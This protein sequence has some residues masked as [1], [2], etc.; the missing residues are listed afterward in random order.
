MTDIVQLQKFLQ[1]LEG[2]GFS[3]GVRGFIS[4]AASGN[5]LTAPANTKRI[6]D[7]AQ[8]SVRQFQAGL[9]NIDEA[10]SLIKRQDFMVGTA[11]G[12]AALGL[13]ALEV[14]YSTSKTEGAYETERDAYLNNA[15]RVALATIAGYKAANA[16]SIGGKMVWYGGA[17]AMVGVGGGSI[18][19]E[20]TGSDITDAKALIQAE[21][22]NLE[23]QASTKRES[24]SA[25]RDEI[26]QSISDLTEQRDNM[27]AP[28]NSDGLR[29]ERDQIASDI[30][31]T[32]RQIDA[33]EVRAG[34]DVARRL[35][36]EGFLHVGINLD[37]IRSNDVDYARYKAADEAKIR[38]LE[39]RL[40]PIDEELFERAKAAGTLESL[41]PAQRENYDQIESS[42]SALNK[43]LLELQSD[44]AL[45]Q[46]E[47]SIIRQREILNNFTYDPTQ[48]TIMDDVAQLYHSREGWYATRDGSFFAALSVAGGTAL[49]LSAD[50]LLNRG[51][52]PA[53]LAG[54]VEI[55]GVPLSNVSRMDSA[56]HRRYIRANHAEL[57]RHAE[58][59]NT[60]NAAMQSAVQGAASS[61]LDKYRAALVQAVDEG[62]IPAEKYDDL[63]RVLDTVDTRIRGVLT[64]KDAT[65]IVR[66][67]RVQPKVVETVAD[68]ATDAVEEGGSFVDNIIH[69][70]KTGSLSRLFGN[71]PAVGSAFAGAGVG[72]LATVAWMQ[73]AHAAELRDAGVI[74]QEGYDA[75]VDMSLKVGAIQGS[76]TT[77]SAFDVVG[78]TIP[79]TLAAEMTTK[80]MFE[81]WYHQY[82]VAME[83]DS[84]DALSKSL[85]ET[86]GVREELVRSIGIYIPRNLEGYTG[87]V[88]EDVIKAKM[89]FV[90]A[91]EENRHLVN[92]NYG[93]II[94]PDRQEAVRLRNEQYWD[95]VHEARDHYHATLAQ[96][97]VRPG[98]MRAYMSLF[99]KHHRLDLARELAASEENHDTF[100]ANHADVSQFVADFNSRGIRSG[101][102]GIDPNS[103][104]LSGD[105]L[106][107]Y[108]LERMGYEKPGSTMVA[109]AAPAEDASDLQISFQNGVLATAIAEQAMRPATAGATSVLAYNR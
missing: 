64:G 70:K 109:E 26:R 19:I 18:A 16:T 29:A 57:A 100:S 60:N 25:Q 90:N 48:S 41:T 62:I 2:Q 83:Q 68:V 58:L 73:T 106:N 32:K 27:L 23:V 86:V 5:K 82:G 54:D 71:I 17:G 22:D 108:I 104:Y 53:L 42:I 56:A 30:E 45:A 65:K 75:Y 12:V 24:L 88:L 46:L 98:G 8:S 13:I 35:E 66:D 91:F 51:S 89:D 10:A 21:L 39:A 3:E 94:D 38:D 80:G 6:L 1:N 31:W 79:V 61:H 44:E 99:P 50:K 97:A 47:Q 92:S 81:D 52:N 93:M 33:Y 15:V 85:F 40:V 28:P 84:V 105:E 72:I 37:D 43:S 34:S 63:S 49:H 101:I 36:A 74:S 11:A 7:D 78:I 20:Q 4:R 67:L 102:F 103:D 9:A 59:I 95:R 107:T 69:F 96:V 87:S 14:D 76:D 55:F 77:L